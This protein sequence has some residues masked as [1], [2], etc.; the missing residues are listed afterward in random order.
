MM[1]VINK[2]ILFFLFLTWGRIMVI[3]IVTNSDGTVCDCR[4]YECYSEE[5]WP[6]LLCHPVQKLASSLSGLSQDTEI[7]KLLLV[8]GQPL[9]TKF[10]PLQIIH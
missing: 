2:K 3:S 4:L 6:R 7:L 10:K 1:F 5:F 8:N 9:A